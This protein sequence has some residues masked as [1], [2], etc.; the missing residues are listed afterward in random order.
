MVAT[1]K[2]M[3]N[4]G[5]VGN[6]KP[7]KAAQSPSARADD[8][9]ASDKVGLVLVVEATSSTRGLPLPSRFQSHREE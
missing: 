4:E 3:M 1:R 7:E 8:G 9:E 6:A 2:K 5:K